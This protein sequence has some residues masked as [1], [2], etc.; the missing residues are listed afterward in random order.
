MDSQLDDL[1]VFTDDSQHSSFRLD[2]LELPLL[3]LVVVELVDPH[4]ILFDG[5]VVA[6]ESRSAFDSQ[7]RQQLYVQARCGLL[8]EF[9]FL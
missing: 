1:P 6:V 7:T 9:L 3:A 2:L 4:E 8:V 5:E